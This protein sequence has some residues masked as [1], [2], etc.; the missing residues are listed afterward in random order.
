MSTIDDPCKLMITVEVCEPNKHRPYKAIY[1]RDQKNV[2]M[3][4]IW[5][6]GNDHIV[7]D[8]LYERHP[9]GQISC[10]ALFG[11]DHTTLLG[12]QEFIY[13]ELNRR[14]EVVQY[15][16]RDGEKTQL[17]KTKF[18]YENDSPCYHKVVVYG[19][20]DEPIGYTLYTYDDAGVAPMGSFTM[21][22]EPIRRFDV[23][24]LF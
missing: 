8:Y 6:D 22:G 24:R 7:R 20:T 12:V 10:V 1:Y 16:I 11:A 21:D 4:H 23:E 19:R 2:V 15:E 13:D 17:Q 9:E 18:C 3:R 14:R 5:V